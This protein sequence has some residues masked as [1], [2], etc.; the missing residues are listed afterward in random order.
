MLN[1]EHRRSEQYIHH[2]R[3]NFV[4]DIN[5]EYS[6]EGEEIILC[7]AHCTCWPCFD[8][9]A[10]FIEMCL[11][12]ENSVKDPLF[13]RKRLCF[14][15]IIFNISQLTKMAKSNLHILLCSCCHI[16]LC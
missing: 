14:Y 1:N 8:I 5:L 4:R 13:Q 10:Y 11:L 2:R 16:F 12:A 7:F 3:I 6:S 9:S 15:Y